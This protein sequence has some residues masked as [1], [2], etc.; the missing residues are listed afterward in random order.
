MALLALMHI[1]GAEGESRYEGMEPW[2]EL[3]T[4]SWGVKAETTWTKG[5]GASVG[6]PNPGEMEWEHYYDSSS[7]M[8]LNYICSGNMFDSVELRMFKT[9][10][11]GQ[12]ITAKT[13]QQTCFFR[14][15][16]NGVFITSVDNSATEEGNVLQK[17]QMVFKEMEIIYRPQQSVG[18]DA[19]KLLAPKRYKWDIPAGTVD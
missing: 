8:I 5:G 12:V 9:T 14:A 15:V 1:S 18:R 6:K 17:V 11:A 10:G 4:W 19:G 7:P 16:M 13:W 2:I 3:Q